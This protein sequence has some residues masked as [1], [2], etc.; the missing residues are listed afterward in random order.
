MYTYIIY[1]WHIFTLYGCTTYTTI[2]LHPPVICTLVLYSLMLSTLVVQNVVSVMA[3]T[4]VVAIH[5]YRR[6]TTAVSV[7]VMT[8]VLSIHVYRRI[9]T[10]VSVMA[11]RC[12]GYPCV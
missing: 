11:D 3:M 9:T 8:D 6:I 7:M 10:A 5:V 2:V 12:C 1:K 4:V